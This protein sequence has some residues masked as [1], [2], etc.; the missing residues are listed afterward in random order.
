MRVLLLMYLIL[1]GSALQS[2]AAESSPSLEERLIRL[3]EGQK[4]LEKRFD[5]FQKH[6]D[7]RFDDMRSYVDQ[8]FDHAD[9]RLIIWKRIIRV[10]ASLREVEKDTVL[11]MYRRELERLEQRIVRLETR[12]SGTG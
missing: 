4:S 6:V 2:E 10:E 1:G 3:E 12:P 9:Q 7:Q 5:D 11:G 8:R